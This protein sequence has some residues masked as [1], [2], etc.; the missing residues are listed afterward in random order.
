MPEDTFDTLDEELRLLLEDC[1]VNVKA[2]AE[3]RSFVVALTIRLAD[4]FELEK[5]DTMRAIVDLIRAIA[6]IGGG[7]RESFGA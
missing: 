3:I 6:S 7:D 4:G 1:G 5:I 2:A